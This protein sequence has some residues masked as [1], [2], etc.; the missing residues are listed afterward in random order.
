MPRRIRG[1]SPF[2]RRRGL[3]QQ[4]QMYT[5]A[6]LQSLNG[7]ACYLTGPDGN[8]Y[9]PA[10]YATQFYQTQMPEL[11]PCAAAPAAAQPAS[12]PTSTVP[13]AATA[14]SIATAV[15]IATTP[16]SQVPQGVIYRLIL[17][18]PDGTYATGANYSGCSQSATNF[19]DPQ[20][21]ET[22]QQAINYALQ[23]NEI[24]VLVSS[25]SQA[26]QIVAGNVVPSAAQILSGASSAS[27]SSSTSAPATTSLLSNPLAIGGLIVAAYL[28]FRK[29]GV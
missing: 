22:L 9:T 18:E 19:C 15:P 23:G 6:Q 21:F 5:L 13:S 24:P 17:A 11:N 16:A 27:T 25:E 12:L 29:K 4:Q 14:L 3:G 10:E 20:S 2:R 8:Q 28:L 7:T 1:L 26:W